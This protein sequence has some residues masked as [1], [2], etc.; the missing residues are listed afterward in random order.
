[1]ARNKAKRQNVLKL[2]EPQL[3]A[4]PAKQKKTDE[5][6]LDQLKSF[7]ALTDNQKE[8]F[9]FY[10]EGIEFITLH[11]VAGTGKTFCAL[12][13]ALEQVLDRS[14]KYRK[15]AIIRSSV[16]SRDMGFL[17]GSADDK[18][19]IYKQP[20]Q[21][22]CEILFGRRDAWSRLEE[23]EVV[24]FLSTSFMRGTSF[25]NTILIV[26]E[27]QN[28]NAGELSTII[29]RVGDNSKIIL[30]GDFR[31][32]DLLKRT[33]DVSGLKDFFEIIKRMNSARKVEFGVEDIVRS[34]LVKEFIIASL[35]Y[36]DSCKS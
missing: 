10:Q 31:Q 32:T 27:C 28:M 36:E 8:F 17:P 2:V 16:Q 33:N 26:D 25:N 6:R 35:A 24:E 21:Q 7:D 4:V 19:N 20:Y 13:K 1:M 11:G 30:C 15:V 9:N 23:Q 3:Y 18:M 34:S 5:I 22:I 14:N 29:T 12:Y